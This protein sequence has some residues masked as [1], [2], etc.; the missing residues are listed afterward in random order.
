MIKM[1]RKAKKAMA[2]ALT[3]GMLAS[4]A[5][6]PVMAATEGWKKNSTGWWY[7]NAD[8]SWPA[9]KW[10]KINGS[11]YYFDANG[12]MKANSCK[13]GK[14]IPCHSLVNSVGHIQYLAPGPSLEVESR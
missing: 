1:S 3:A 9:N 8:G 14:F 12:Y 6:T 4:T 2:V 10:E 11:W 7:Q 13:N 5:A